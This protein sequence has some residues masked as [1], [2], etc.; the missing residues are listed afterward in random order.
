[1]LTLKQRVMQALGHP[2]S[3]FELWPDFTT[4]IS[5]ELE[6]LLTQLQDIDDAM[7]ALV[8]DSNVVQLDTIKLDVSKG[9]KSLR[10]QGSLKLKY[11]AAITGYPLAYDRYVPPTRLSLRNSR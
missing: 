3:A 10:R 6:A 9:L 7:A 5:T 8:S 1:M 4:D 2:A 11:I